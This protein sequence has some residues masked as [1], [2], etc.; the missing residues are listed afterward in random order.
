LNACI[1]FSFAMSSEN[2]LTYMWNLPDSQVGP[3]A[4]AR[5]PEEDQQ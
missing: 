1:S 2:G 4:G 5:L 3:L